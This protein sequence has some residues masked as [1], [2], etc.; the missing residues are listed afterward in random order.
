MKKIFLSMILLLNL[1]AQNLEIDKLRTDLYSKSGTN[2]LKKIEIS[3]EFQGDDLQENKN[4]LI[5]SIN[6]VISGFFYED[7]FTEI[8]KNNFKKTLEKFVDK[9]YKIKLN[10]IYILSLSG[11]EKF[12]LEEFKRFLQST[13]TQEENIGE[14]VKQTLQDLEPP[15][16]QDLED[17]N[18]SK[19]IE[20]LFKDMPKQEQNDEQININRLNIPKITQENNQQ[21]LIN[22]LFEIL[23]QNDINHFNNPSQNFYGLTPEN[24][25]QN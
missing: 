22:N 16:T 11:I 13:Q 2:I 25:M 4:K 24:M 7:I 23:N 3:L 9:K 15:K 19:S 6:T 21:N 5:D 20:E 14:E 10:D 1:S 8:G 12:D 18:A 17:L